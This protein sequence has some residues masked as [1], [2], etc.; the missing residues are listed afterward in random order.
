MATRSLKSTPHAGPDL[1]G[2]GPVTPQGLGYEVAFLTVAEEQTL[3]DAFASLPLAPFQFGAFEGKRRV[4]SFGFRYDYSDQRLHEAD[5]IPNFIRLYAARAESFAHLSPGA[6]RH[7]LFTEYETGAGI[8]WH[9]DKANFDVVLGI[10]LGSAC[11]FRFRKKHGHAWQRF[12]LEA[13]PRSIYVMDGDARSVWEHSIAPVAS[14]RWSITFRTMA[15][16]KQKR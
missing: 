3:I 6:V 11:P 12:T 4:A 7:V 9:R 13:E 14:P 5:P 8:G 16:G 10:S 15:D 1:F 2:H